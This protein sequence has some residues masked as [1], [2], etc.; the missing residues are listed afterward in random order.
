MFRTKV[1]NQSTSKNETVKSAQKKTI[2]E[3]E[4][5]EKHT[6]SE[7]DINTYD[8]YVYYDSNEDLYMALDN[9]TALAGAELLR[10]RSQDKI[11]TGD[12]RLYISETCMF[13]PWNA[14]ATA[15]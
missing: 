8:S 13:P 5:S 4:E 11:E 15:G 9:F 7:S 12:S 2:I 6:N 1:N 10:V 14:S 3:E